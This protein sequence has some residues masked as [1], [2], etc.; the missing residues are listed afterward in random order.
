MYREYFYKGEGPSRREITI[1]RSRI[2]ETL[3]EKLEGLDRAEL[4]RPLRIS[5]ENENGIDEGN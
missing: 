5:F 4:A 1:T 2:I 3:A